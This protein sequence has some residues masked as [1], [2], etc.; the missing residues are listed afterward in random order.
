MNITDLRF[1]PAPVFGALEKIQIGQLYELRLRA[2]APITLNY[3]FKRLY[4]GKD[5]LTLCENDAI[6]CD[7]DMIEETVF[8]AADFSIYAANE[9]IVRGFITTKDGV[10]I[11]IGGECVF[12]N[13]KLITIKNFSSLCIRIPHFVEGCASEIYRRVFNDG[14]KNVLIVSAPG[15]GKTTIL[16]DLSV[17]LTKNR[18]VLIIDERGEL[19]DKRLCMGD[20]IK[21]CDKSYAF[22][23]GIRSL[24]PQVVITDELSGKNDW[25][26]IRNAVNCGVKVI[27]TAH[28]DVLS[29]I[30][31]RAEFIDGLFKRYVLLY[32]EGQA[33]RIKN[34]YDERGHELL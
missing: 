25:E 13:S 7:S 12:E 34:I 6:R 22:S 17:S 10:R 24:A 16:K 2:D 30:R 1:L 21:Y 26:C 9:S 4:L 23:Y 14:I 19:S 8:R 32:S 18:N 28:G 15:Y 11:G 3:G 20:V 31:N 29:D 5:S 33:G 27:A